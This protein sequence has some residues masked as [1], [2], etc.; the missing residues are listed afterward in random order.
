MISSLAR[1][2]E[3]YLLLAAWEHL[4]EVN[5]A[6]PLF[7]DST[8]RALETSVAFLLANHASLLLRPSKYRRHC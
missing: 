7:N 2:V 8:I 3:W 1:F 4:E 5:G 6:A